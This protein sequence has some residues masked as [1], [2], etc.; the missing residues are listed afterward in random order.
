MRSWSSAPTGAR[1]ERLRGSPA[2]SPRIVAPEHPLV[3]LQRTLGNLAVQ[4]LLASDTPAGAGERLQ[5]QAVTR[6][7]EA[8]QE[9]EFDGTRQV[10][11][12][13]T[14]SAGTV[15]LSYDPAQAVL[16][17]TFPVKWRYPRSWG[18]EQRQ[19][20]NE[21]F[22]AAV[23]RAWSGR[24]TLVEYSGAG[25]RARPTGRTAQVRVRFNYI[26]VPDFDN[27]T[28]YVNWMVNTPQASGRWTLQV[29]PTEIRDEV[30][31]PVV[32]L[33]PPATWRRPPPPRSSTAAGSGRRGRAGASSRRRTSTTSARASR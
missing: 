15:N 32:E 16:E 4:R 10:R 13:R 22:Q 24:Y 8:I 25:R 12:T 33:D 21:A 27:D 6:E 31:Y 11:T 14:I 2:A 26:T 7:G 18:Y 1:V 17:C 30:R 23:S 5:R 9:Y 20:Y 19:G 3:G 28:E 29:S